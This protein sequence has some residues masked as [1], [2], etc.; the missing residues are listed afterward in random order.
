M[1]ENVIENAV[2]LAFLAVALA[3]IVENTI[4]RIYDN[5][6]WL[7][8]HRWTIVFWSVAF[9]I[10]LC[11]RA[12]IGILGELAVPDTYI[13][14]GVIVGCGASVFWDIVLDS[15]SS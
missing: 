2:V 9:G 6:P 1:F 14:A 8:P 15:A 10:A 3:K 13:L 11:W 12:R 5:I 4:G 7:R